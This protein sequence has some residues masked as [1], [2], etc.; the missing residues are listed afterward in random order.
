MEIAPRQRIE[1]AGIEFTP[2]VNL[3]V[4]LCCV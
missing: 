1:E 2:T 4:S 3:F